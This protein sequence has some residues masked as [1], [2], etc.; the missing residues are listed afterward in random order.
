MKLYKNLVM[1]VMAFSFNA[2]AANA[3][4]RELTVGSITTYPNGTIGFAV[5][6]TLLNP[7]SCGLTSKYLLDSGD[8]GKN[9]LSTLLVA[10]ATNNLIDVSVSP[11]K[12][13]SDYP[14]VVRL[15]LR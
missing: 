2:I 4:H 8:G 15:I 11:T 6:K 9:M 7:A 5:D 3:E 13:L 12:C 10:K 1:M 14:V